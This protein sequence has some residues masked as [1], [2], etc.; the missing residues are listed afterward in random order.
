VTV[1]S[2]GERMAS[3]APYFYVNVLVVGNAA[4]ITVELNEHVL[5]ERNATLAWATT[6]YKVHLETDPTAESIRSHIKGEI[7]EFL[8]DWLSVNPKKLQ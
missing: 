2:E 3:G 6:W 5:I 4:A 7:D 1:I 8:N